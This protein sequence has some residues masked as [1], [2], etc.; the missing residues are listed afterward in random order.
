MPLPEEFGLNPPCPGPGPGLTLAGT[1]S[2][3]DDDDDGKDKGKDKLKGGSC[4]VD[5][6]LDFVVWCACVL[7]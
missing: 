6:G 7:E 1:E 2:D 5:V 3:N 4:N